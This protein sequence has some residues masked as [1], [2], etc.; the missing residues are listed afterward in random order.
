MSRLPALQVMMPLSEF[1]T[2]Y[3]SAQVCVHEEPVVSPAHWMAL[4]AAPV[5]GSGEQPSATGENMEQSYHISRD[6]GSIWCLHVRRAGYCTAEFEPPV[7]T[8]I[9]TFSTPGTRM[10]HVPLQAR[11]PENPRSPRGHV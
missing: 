6:L 11:V 10:P 7:F 5:V 3:P 9:S 1:E 8:A 4:Y 2:E